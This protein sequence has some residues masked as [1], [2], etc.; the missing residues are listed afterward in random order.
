MDWKKETTDKNYCGYCTNQPGFTF[1]DGSCFTRTDYPE[2]AVES[3]KLDHVKTEL[4]KIPELRK[5]L[6]QREKDL[7]E[8]LEKLKP[9]K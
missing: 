5:A 2:G 1:C 8:E 9:K 4:K 6:R 3:Y 7:R